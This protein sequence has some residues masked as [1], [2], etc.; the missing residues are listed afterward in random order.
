MIIDNVDRE[1]RKLKIIIFCLSSKVNEEC[2]TLT[3]L[4]TSVEAWP[5]GSVVTS[6]CTGFMGGI[7]R[8]KWQLWNLGM[9]FQVM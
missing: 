9:Q 4:L 3:V 6:P 8:V 1:S 5:G 2:T 7:A